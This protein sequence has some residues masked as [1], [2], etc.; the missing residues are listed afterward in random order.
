MKTHLTNNGAQIT[1]DERRM[2][3]NSSL[4]IGRF[5]A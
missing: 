2:E 5:F 3:I 1:N 4:V